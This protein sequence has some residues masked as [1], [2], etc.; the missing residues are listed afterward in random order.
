M[1]TLP[2]EIVTALSA[3]IGFLVTNGLKALFPSWDIS[4]VAAKVT[5][6]LVTCVVAL[7][8]QALLLVPEQYRPVVLT[9]FTLIIAILGAYG[10]H[11]TVKG[12]RVG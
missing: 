12:S 8:N 4:G 3:V 6:A 7:A 9:V 10:I 2:V 1:F 11:F 5:A